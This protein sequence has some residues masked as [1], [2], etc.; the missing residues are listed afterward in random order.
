MSNQLP[1][2]EAHPSAVSHIDT[3]P[4]A[5]VAHAGDLEAGDFILPHS[6]AKA[7]FI[8]ASEGVMTVITASGAFPGPPRFAV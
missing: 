1:S 7:Q 3:T 6:H 2:G 4:Q 5:V 8:Y